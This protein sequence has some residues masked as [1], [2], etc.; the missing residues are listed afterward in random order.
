MKM[1]SLGYGAMLILKQEEKH[2][3]EFLSIG[4]NDGDQ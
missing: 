2:E 4:S 1:S 3:E